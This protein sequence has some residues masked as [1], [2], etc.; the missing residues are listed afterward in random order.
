MILVE[1]AAWWYAA[2]WAA[3]A[4]RA[5]RRVKTTLGYFSVGLLAKTLFD[6]FRQIDAGRARGSLQAQW[7]AFGDRLVSRIIGAGVRTVV[8]FAG[9]VSALVIGVVGLVQ[10]VIWPLVPLLPIIG[11]AL[12]AMGWTP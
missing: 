7:H 8:I 1:T 9:L 4:R 3:L 12:A 11:I 2:G 5:G 10:L 6:P